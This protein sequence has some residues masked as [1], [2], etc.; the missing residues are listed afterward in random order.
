ML[1]GPSQ[2]LPGSFFRS[3]RW[4]WLRANWL[5]ERGR[6]ASTRI[7]DDWVRR[8]KRCVVATHPQKPIGCKR[9]ARPDAA[10]MAASDLAQE[11]S[12][13]RRWMVEALL[14]TDEPLETIA[15]KV[16]LPVEIAEAYAQVFWD[17]RSNLR[18]S[19]WV[20]SHAIGTTWLEGFAGLPLGSLWKYAAYTAGPRA[21]EV[22]IAV[23]LEQPLPNWW[24]ASFA[25]SADALYAES[26]FRF[27]AKLTVAALTAKSPEELKPLVDARSQLDR[28]ERK[29][30][31][32]SGDRS[33]MLPAM[34]QFLKTCVRRRKARPKPVSELG[35]IRERVFGLGGDVKARRRMP[36]NSPLHVS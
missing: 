28:V 6:R 8:A 30:G 16:D 20:M 9:S 32:D 18:A 1:A 31:V 12:P 27:K 14:L 24:R 5:F 17:V 7:D 33:G 10:V 29:E 25:D 22:T 35:Q 2:W 21:L 23:T 15:G 4:R 26:R 11:E 13:H 34:E 3:P 36:K 19:D